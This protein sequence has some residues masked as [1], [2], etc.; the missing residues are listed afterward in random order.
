M[1]LWCLF[2][3]CLVQTLFVIGVSLVSFQFV[4]YRGCLWLVFLLCMFTVC[5]FQMLFVVG[6]SF[7]SFHSLFSL[8]IV[9][10]WCCSRGWA[11]APD[12]VSDAA[13]SGHLPW[14]VQQGSHR[15]R[16]TYCLCVFS[17]LSVAFLFWHWFN[18][19]LGVLAVWTTWSLLTMPASSA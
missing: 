18:I 17:F 3:V 15:T 1:F 14:Q 10:G 8:D 12:S 7:V 11:W 4:W 5:L 16:Y 19:E 2:T 9:C 13:L 6:V